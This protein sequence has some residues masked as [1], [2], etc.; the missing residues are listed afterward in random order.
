MVFQELSSSVAPALVRGWDDGTTP[1]QD[2]GRRSEQ[3]IYGL[4]LWSHRRVFSP[5][6]SGG[7]IVKHGYKG[8]GILIHMLVDEEGM[9]LSVGTTPANGD[10]PAQINTLLEPVKVQ[11]GNRVVL[12]NV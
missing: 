10:Q 1:V 11:Q 9:P 2:F 5:G 7:A 6:K 12:P 3:R 4:G 8:K